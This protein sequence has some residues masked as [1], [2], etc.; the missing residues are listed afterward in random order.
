MRLNVFFS[1]RHA[2]GTCIKKNFITD[3]KKSQNAMEFLL[4]LCYAP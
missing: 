1:L 4:R 2:T 3:K